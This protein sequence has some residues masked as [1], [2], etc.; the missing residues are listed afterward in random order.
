MLS[1]GISAWSATWS[2]H[3]LSHDKWMIIHVIS[4]W[5][6]M[7][8]VHDIDVISAWSVSWSVHDLVSDHGLITWLSCM[9]RHEIIAWSVTWS[10]HDQTRDQCMTRHVI[11]AFF[12]LKN[13]NS[14]PIKQ[15]LF[16]FSF[17]HPWYHSTFYEFA[18]ILSFIPQ[19]LLLSTYYIHTW[20]VNEWI[21]I[22]TIQKQIKK[23]RSQYHLY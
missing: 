23:E 15:L 1:H 19:L 16:I 22:C 8:S 20:W 10:V 12:I 17:H 21:H 13:W 3:D 4:A 9:I 7:W 18:A 6:V 5:A 11:S 14:L 2:V